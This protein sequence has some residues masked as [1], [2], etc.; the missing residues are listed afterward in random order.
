[1]KHEH[2]EYKYKELVEHTLGGYSHPGRNGD[3]RVIFGANLSI[4]LQKDGFPIIQGRKM[5]PEGV[6]G[7]LATFISGD[8][9]HV[10]R[11]RDNGCNYW[12][13]FAA[14]DGEL[15]MMYGNIWRNYNGIDQLK[16][17]I[18]QLKHNP[19]SRQIIM[20]SYDP[21][22]NDDRIMP[23]HMLYQWNVSKGYLLDMLWMQRSVDLM[24]GL[25]SDIILAAVLNILIANEVGL[26]PNSLHFMLGNCHIYDEHRDGARQYIKQMYIEENY[27]HWLLSK[28]AN[29]FNFRPDMFKIANYQALSAINFTLIK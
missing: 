29:L 20:T 25:P 7:E 27:F 13:K 2:W 1:M 5:Y 17:V 12:D 23:C 11:F 21:K 19:N 26:I 28:D 22:P 8:C 18:E 15:K 14:E 4:N 24:I 10:Q 16:Q 3:T 6:L 9:L